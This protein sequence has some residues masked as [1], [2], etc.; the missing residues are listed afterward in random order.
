M[1]IGEAEIH[2]QAAP[3]FDFGYSP[4]WYVVEEMNCNFI[5]KKGR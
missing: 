3:D 1:T 2:F 5:K 4:I